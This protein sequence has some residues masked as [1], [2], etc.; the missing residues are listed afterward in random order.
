MERHAVF[1]RAWYGTRGVSLEEIGE[2]RGRVDQMLADN[3]G[4][5]KSTIDNLKNVTGAFSRNSGRID[6][7]MAGLERLAGGGPAEKP[8]P[9]Y[10]LASPT[11]AAAVSPAS[12]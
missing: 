10:D 7:I 3:S 6:T 2:F 8:K 12:I 5:V 11:P 9:M 4:G 1:E